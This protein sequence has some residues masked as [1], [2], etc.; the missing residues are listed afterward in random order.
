MTA[1]QAQ[2]P[3]A[4]SSSLEAFDQLERREQFVFRKKFVVTSAFFGGQLLPGE[5]VSQV[6]GSGLGNVLRHASL[7]Q[8]SAQVDDP[9]IAATDELFQ[10]H[11]AIPHTHARLRLA[12]FETYGLSLQFTGPARRHSKDP[13]AW[14]AEA[15]PLL[16]PK[17]ELIATAELGSQAI[18]AAVIE[19]AASQPLPGLA[20]TE[21]ATESTTK[22]TSEP[23]AS[24]ASEDIAAARK[25]EPC[26]GRLGENWHRRERSR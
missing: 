15:S 16:V 21:S 13:A 18:A 14:I 12:M 4:E 22:P 7:G 17:A 6:P 5:S 1:A 24:K 20:A 2:R 8:Q 10:R 25:A 3:V 19:K 26:A 11:D 9:R 23:A